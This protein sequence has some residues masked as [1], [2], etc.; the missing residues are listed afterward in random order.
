MPIFDYLCGCG[1]RFEALVSSVDGP[2][3]TCRNCGAEPRRLVSAARLGGKADPG[4]GREAAPKS[5]QATGRGDP[6]TLRYWHTQMTKREKLEQKYPELAG[7]RRP[8]LAHEG[9]FAANPLRAGDPLP[10]LPPPKSS[11]PESPLAKN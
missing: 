10:K 4:P 1:R 9:R 3:P 2:A 5:W 8:V 11:P 7:D 6:E